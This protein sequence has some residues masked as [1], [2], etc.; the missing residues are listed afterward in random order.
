M[1]GEVVFLEATDSVM[2]AERVFSNHHLRHAPVVSDGTLVGML[3]LMDLQKL[4]AFDF[5]KTEE[6]ERQQ[7]IL[8]EM[9]VRR[10]MSNDPVSVQ[11]TSTVREVAETL[12]DNEFH[13]LPVM[14]G[15]Q[16]VGIISSTDL[17]RFLAE[18]IQD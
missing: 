14:D 4:P 13:A 8:R 17:M 9:P 15:E 10:I 1:T 11:Q 6:A 3:S 5:F 7:I 12:A 16:V 2:E 18:H